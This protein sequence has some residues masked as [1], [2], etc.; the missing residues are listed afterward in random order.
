M[1]NEK[2]METEGQTIIVTTPKELTQIVATAMR[3]VLENPG[4]P[5]AKRGKKL[6]S[7]RDIEQEYGI[8][9]RTL[10]HW[11]SEGT[12]PEYTTVGGRIYYERARME[13]YIAA[14]RVRPVDC[15]GAC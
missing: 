11:R 9:K 8:A 7:A 2:S 15:S 13:D 14:G 1:L 10:E 4:M 6:L 12:G 3:S 5:P